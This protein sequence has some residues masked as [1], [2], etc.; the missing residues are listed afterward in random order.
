MMATLQPKIVGSIMKGMGE[1]ER[2]FDRLFKA[3]V[4]LV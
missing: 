4:S 3:R 1:V 2:V